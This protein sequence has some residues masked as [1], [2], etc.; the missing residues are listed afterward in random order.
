[1]SDLAQETIDYIAVSRL[2][3]AYA[4][5][6]TRRAWDELD[7]IFVPEIPIS[8]DLRDRDPYEFASRDAFKEFVSAAVDRFEFFEFVILNS[9]VYLEHAGDPDAAVARMYMS[10]LRQDHAERRWTAV[11]GVY[12][13]TFRRIEGQWWF[14]ARN[15]SSLARPAQD[16]VAFDFPSPTAF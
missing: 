8:I 3:H 10:E 15:Y 9:R 7:E 4:D 5:I 2:H 6:A 11:Y 12:H 16:I 1:M 13:D 14:V